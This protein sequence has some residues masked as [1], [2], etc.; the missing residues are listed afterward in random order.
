[1]QVKVVFTGSRDWP[2]Y[3]MVWDDL[4]DLAWGAMDLGHVTLHVFV[5]DC[6]SGVDDDVD[7]WVEN[8]PYIHDLDG[9]Q[10][11][12]QLHYFRAEWDVYGKGAGPVRNMRMVEA[13][14]ADGVEDVQYRA[15][16]FNGSAGT[17]NCVG[18]LIAAGVK[19]VLVNMNIVNT[20]PK[21]DD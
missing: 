4:W 10:I 15:Y 8:H 21:V 12:I 16:N 20:L 11:R 6:P 18:H 5:G 13:A 1:M 3:S 17:A 9:R 19:G 2:F 7:K 14:T